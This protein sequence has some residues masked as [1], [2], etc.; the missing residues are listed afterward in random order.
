LDLDGNGISFTPLNK[1]TATYDMDHSGKRRSTAWIK[2]GDGLLAIDLDGD[3]TIDKTDEISFT[4]YKKGAKTDLEGLQAF[5]TNQNGTL[6]AGDAAWKKFGVWQDA[7]QN[8]TNEAGEFKTLDEL[9][10]ASISLTSDHKQS[11][12]NDVTTYG[13]TTFTRKD[14]TTGQVADAAFSY[15][16]TPVSQAELNRRYDELLAAIATQKPKSAAT[17]SIPANSNTPTL[18]TLTKHG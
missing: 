7:N 5:D 4:A 17:T 12:A 14:G 18:P 1:S 13:K 9:G 15:S 8:G 10:I 11:Q 16:K 3:R 2:P 6:D